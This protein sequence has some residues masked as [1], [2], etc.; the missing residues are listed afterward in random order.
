MNASSDVERPAATGIPTL[1][2]LD[3]LRE[4]G[5]GRDVFFQHVRS[6]GDVMSAPVHKLTLDHNLGDAVKLM[7]DQRIRHVPL[8][9]TEGGGEAF[10]GIVSHR[11][12]ARQLSA[13]IGTAAEAETDQRML[14]SPLSSVVTRKPAA[15]TPT[16]GLFDV[17]NIMIERKVDCVP[18]LDADGTI[19]GIITSTDAIEIFQVLG[20][21]QRMTGITERRKGRLIGLK[22]G[23]RPIGS[24]ALIES[25][26]KTVHDLMTE[27]P[28]TLAPDAPLAAAIRLMQE[29]RVRHVPVVDASK[30]V[31]GLVSDVDVLHALP[32]AVERAPASPGAAPGFRD[33]LFATAEK[34]PAL[35]TPLRLVLPRQNPKAR[36][37]ASTPIPDATRLMIAEQL[38]GVLVGTDEKGNGLEGILTTT[39]ILRG[40]YVLGQL[41]GLV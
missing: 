39:D 9:D 26:F 32:P 18:V 1:R 4:I 22:G 25:H 11:D 35:E 29:Q 7:A 37:A 27:Q 17:I 3:L 14:K 31:L 12:V 21:I 38:T 34:E 23:R 5:S 33:R 15:A 40:V 28:A 30:R 20:Q 41:L 24:R 16:T 13:G 19:V 6:A 2:L 36:I 8:V 10:I